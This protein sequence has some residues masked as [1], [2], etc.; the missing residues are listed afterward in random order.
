M[1]RDQGTIRGKKRMS[2]V[3]ACE[4]AAES[5][6][7]STTMLELKVGDRVRSQMQRVRK[8]GRRYLTSQVDMRRLKT[9]R[10]G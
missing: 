9:A 2:L 10:S 7:R 5:I 3:T 6:A 8:V 4:R 1:G